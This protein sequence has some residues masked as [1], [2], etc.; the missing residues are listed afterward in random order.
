MSDPAPRRLRL[1]LALAR[2]ALWWELAWPRLCF[3]VALAGTFLALALLDV[4]PMLPGWLHAAVLAAFALGLV[5][6]VAPV[7]R[8]RLPDREQAQRRLERDSG[9]PH[10]PLATLGDRIAAGADDPTATALWHRHLARVRLEMPGLALRP[11]SPG[12]AHREPWGLRA[13]VLLLLTVGI[14]AGADDPFGRLGRAV[15]PVLTGGTVPATT[16]A[17]LK[18]PDYTGLPPV[19]LRGPAAAKN[20]EADGSTGHIP[21]TIGVPH[22]ST[23]IARAWPLSAPPRLV[24]G[25]HEVPFAPIEGG[26]DAAPTAY[27]AQ[28]R[29]DDGD[30]I[31]VRRH[32]HTLARW[33]IEVVADAP[34]QAQW[35]A[36][37]QPEANG[38]FRLNYQAR[39]DYRVTALTAIVQPAGETG[40]EQAPVATRKRL[41]IALPDAA[42]GEI[43]GSQVFDLADHAWAGRPVT[44]TLEATDGIG[45]TARSPAVDFVLPERTFHHPVAREIVAVRKVL[46]ESGETTL[47]RAQIAL[48]IAAGRPDAFD[49]DAVVSLALAVARARLQYDHGEAAIASVRRILWQTALRI[50]EGDVPAARNAVAAAGRALADA[51]RDD[52]PAATIDRLMDALKDALGRYLDAVSAEMARRGETP[53]AP[54]D[55]GEYLTGKDLSALLAQADRLIGIGA[56]AAAGRLLGSLQQLIAGAQD[57]PGAARAREALRAER[58]L[59]DALRGLA[60][61]QQDLADDTARHLQERGRAGAPRK[62]EKDPARAA[63][64]RQDQLR[65][66]LAEAARQAGRALGTAP[67]ALDEAGDAMGRAREALDQGRPVDAVPEQTAAVDALKRGERALGRAFAER[68]AGGDGFLLF[69]G[70]G[71]A[72]GADPFGRPPGDGG[73]GFGLGQIAIPEATELRRAQAIVEELRRRAGEADRPR[74]ERDYIERLLRRF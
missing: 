57:G 26:N 18:P 64:G 27:A 31:V 32:G 70:S 34:P 25:T 8:L 29:V 74:L 61:D 3:A 66:R 68:H 11:P 37:P 7:L 17:W 50:E 51:L 72:F 41:T 1:L 16:E 5:V 36:P 35:S 10:R 71:G 15:S 60:N 33:P 4:L 49:N 52:A 12:M 67:P 59:L 63:A 22:G 47:L 2:F 44:L 58:A 46:L 19:F 24:I 54:A 20:K 40:G 48:I 65:Q 53:Q 38:R 43:T 55:L 6:L 21:A 69:G 62:G 9:V 42:A 39:D 13:G 23:V 28:A 73:R 45:Q 14:A 56:R 30:A